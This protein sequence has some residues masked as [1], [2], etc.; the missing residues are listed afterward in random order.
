MPNTN[1]LLL[2]RGPASYVLTRLL[3]EGDP[4]LAAYLD[5]SGNATEVE[6][7]GGHDLENKIVGGGFQTVQGEPA[8]QADLGVAVYDG[9]STIW[10]SNGWTGGKP[11]DG[12]DS[13]YEGMINA[14]NFIGWTPIGGGSSGLVP[15]IYGEPDVQLPAGS[16]FVDLSDQ[17][18]WL[19]LGW[20]GDPLG[21]N[22]NTPFL[23]WLGFCPCKVINVSSQSSS[24]SSS[25]SGSTN[26][27]SNVSAA[28]CPGGVSATLYLTI[29][30]ACNTC[31]NGTWTMT[32]DPANK[33]WI[34]ERQLL[35]CGPDPL[36]VYFILE[37]N[38]GQWQLCIDFAVSNP[39]FGTG[40]TVTFN[41]TS[42]QCKPFDIEGANVPPAPGTPI[43]GD[44]VSICG[45][46]GA[47]TW[48]VVD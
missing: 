45:A 32:Y 16:Q 48:S 39:S 2:H 37:D 23:G 42:V 19:S 38:G 25:G 35:S 43:D 15:Y 36:S 7:I 10:V 21:I 27:N 31:L 6:Y 5:G 40:S 9:S 28:G 3:P 12:I 17:M 34:A 41:T 29:S 24:G 47:I 33:W 18:Y 14:S 13:P 46:S 4:F 30:N 26:G 22:K 8:F 20:S 1:T 11:A 44:Y